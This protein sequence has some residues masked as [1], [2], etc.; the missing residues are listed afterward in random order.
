MLFVN[1]SGLI[2]TLI[3]LMGEN[4]GHH[5]H[6]DSKTR[7]VRQTSKGNEQKMRSNT[8]DPSN[9]HSD[10]NHMYFNEEMFM[11]EQKNHRVSEEI[12][13]FQ[14]GL[15]TTKGKKQKVKANT[16]IPESNFISERLTEMNGIEKKFIN[17]DK[18]LSL[19]QFRP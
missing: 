12:D 11:M 14:K 3:F 6:H 5:H 17:T 18:L 13:E 2:R 19:L 4:E 16:Q 1:Q 9:D 8:S 7:H 15:A 10:H